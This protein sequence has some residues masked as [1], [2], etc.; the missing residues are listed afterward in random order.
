MRTLS[1]I[2]T[3][4]KIVALLIF[5]VTFLK[6]SNAQASFIKVCPGNEFDYSNC[7]VNTP[8]KGLWVIGST[9]SYGSGNYDVYVIKV[10]SNNEVLWSKTFDWGKNEYGLSAVVTQDNG[11]AITGYANVSKFTDSGWDCFVLKLDASGHSLWCKSITTP[12]E[13]YANGI[14]QTGNGD[15]LIAGSTR[16]YGKGLNDIYLA[17]FT[18][19][20]ILVWTKTLGTPNE[21]LAYSIT[22]V[23]NGFTIAGAANGYMPFVA[24]LDTA[25][26]IVW[27][28]NFTV[29]GNSTGSFNSIIQTADHGFAATGFIGLSGRGNDV[30]TI[31]LLTNGNIEWAKTSG[32]DG[33]DKGNGITEDRAG[34]IISTG[35]FDYARKGFLQ[36]LNVA[37]LDHSGNLVW[38]KTITQEIEA[39]GSSVT[40]AANGENIAAGLIWQTSNGYLYKPDIY[41]TSFGGDGSLCGTTATQ[42]AFQNFI[43]H[44]D[45]LHFDVS[46]GG[47][48]INNKVTSYTGGALTNSCSQFSPKGAAEN[49]STISKIETNTKDF[50][51]LIAPNP[52]KNNI[53]NLY[54]NCKAASDLMMQILSADG[55]LM[56]THKLTLPAHASNTS[57][58]I[59]S[60]TPGIYLLKLN[61]NFV[62]QTIKFIKE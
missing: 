12:R 40:C 20:G 22:A 46:G 52:V 18:H 1:H 51:V 11:L 5:G 39:S 32:N 47:T 56:I 55:K 58:N 36:S 6:N 53:L 8:E 33:D 44:A 38:N 27:S 61:N 13:D 2:S 10:D 9:N 43:P 15:L 60:L 25:G 62:G 34:N 37:K 45:N 41:L 50:K 19:R 16:S 30:L 26:N 4:L 24:K 42:T 7:I 49:K 48:V 59:A 14:T 31:K 57:V 3:R 17:K 29:S 35:Y 28:K 21:D 23:K 54:F